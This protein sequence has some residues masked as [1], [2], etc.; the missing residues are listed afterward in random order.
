MKY[1][2]STEEAWRRIRALRHKPLNHAERGARKLLFSAASKQSEQFFK[3]ADAAGYEIKPILL[4]YGLNQAARAIAASMID[5]EK[6]WELQGHGITCHNLNDDLSLGELVVSNQNRSGAFEA[7]AD[8]LGSPTLSMK[9][10]LQAIW[11]SLPEGA[12]VPLKGAEQL[13]G[14]AKLKRIDGKDF[15]A[16]LATYPWD[17]SKP[18]VRLSHLPYALAPKNAVSAV[19]LL[20]AKYPRL[21][22]FLPVWDEAGNTLD[23]SWSSAER[24]SLSMAYYGGEAPKQFAVT[25]FDIVRCGMPGYG[26]PKEGSTWVI[27]AVG[28]NSRP[29]NPLITWWAVLYTLSMLARYKPNNWTRMLDIDVS[30]DAPAIEYML[31]EGHRACI[32]LIMNVFETHKLY[33]RDP[34]PKGVQEAVQMRQASI[35]RLDAEIEDMIVRYTRNRD[36]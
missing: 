31:D 24:L 21:R 6:K 33:H 15:L 35:A 23:F 22:N 26:D 29:M 32:N 3:S 10:P 9:V 11:M 13:W 8:I 4:Y 7:L 17:K 5:D 30:P 1:P 34:M 18:V 16:D 14:A 28:D 2:C 25:G 19:E 20:R 36:G 27:P 12:T